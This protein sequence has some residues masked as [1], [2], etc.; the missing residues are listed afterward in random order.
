[1]KIRLSVA[2]VLL[3]LVIGACTPPSISSAADSAVATTGSIATPVAAQTRPARP[4]AKA[5]MATLFGDLDALQAGKLAQVRILQIGDSHTAGDYFTGRLRELFQARFGNAGRGA[6]LPGRPYPGV[7]FPDLSVGQS[8]GWRMYNI[9][10]AD[11]AQPF[12][13]TGFV[14]VSEQAGATMRVTLADTGNFQRARVDFIR[15]PGGG[16]LQL[17]ADNQPVLRQSTDGPAGTPGSAIVDLPTPAQ[18]LNVTADARGIA[19]TEW[20]LE[21]RT[22][23]VLVEGFGVVGATVRIVQ[24]WDQTLAS[25]AFNELSPNLVILAFGTN[26]GA[27]TALQP[28]NYEIEFVAAINRIKA[29]APQAAILVVGP[30]DGQ[31]P[32]IN[33]KPPKAGKNAQSQPKNCHWT[34]LPNLDKVRAVQRRAAQRAGVEFWDWS[35]VMP[36]T[37]GIDAW[38]NA[39]P[40]LARPDHVH[41][42]PAGYA[43]SADRLFA[44]LMDEYRRYNGGR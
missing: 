44:Q 17:F 16:T 31:R 36:K 38:V 19:I 4:P 18:T 3:P 42:S 27:E 9:R 24:R 1:M 28:D 34:R 33:C 41:L 20:Q 25:A 39:D 23:G 29:L 12:A 37:N 2:V 10:T 5:G 40:P 26:E 32:G 21:R 7:R 15:K 30:P 6:M 8:A 11:P 14:A 35:Q 43:L 13:P 22:P